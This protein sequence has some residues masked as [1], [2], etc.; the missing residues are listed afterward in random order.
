MLETQPQATGSSEFADAAD[1]QTMVGAANLKDPSLFRSQPPP[2]LTQD[3]GAGGV[4]DEDATEETTIEFCEG[5]LDRD[6]D[7][8]QPKTASAG[9]DDKTRYYRPQREYLTPED[10]S[11]ELDTAGDSEMTRVLGPQPPKVILAADVLADAAPDP[12]RAEATRRKK[13]RWRQNT[14][15]K[16]GLS[17]CLIGGL[18]LA[19]SAAA[20]HPK[21][22]PITHDAFARVAA[23]AASL[24]SR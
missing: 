19:L 3:E 5:L 9:D 18:A 13:R 16:L 12:A 1:E 17:M 7:A 15:T 6:R 4:E 21:T 11:E 24:L 20:R 22:A 23:V 8:A 14:D 10:A 2:A